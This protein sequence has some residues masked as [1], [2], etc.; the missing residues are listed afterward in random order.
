MRRQLNAENGTFIGP[1]AA[2]T[3]VRYAMQFVLIGRG[4]IVET[5]SRR[6]VIELTAN[7]ELLELRAM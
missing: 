6:W 4:M 3:M 7:W 1:V 2:A 5:I